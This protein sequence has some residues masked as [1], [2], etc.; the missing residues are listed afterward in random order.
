MAVWALA[1]LH[2]SFGVPNKEMDVFGEVWVNHPKKIEA[3][4][5]AVVGDDDLVLIAGDISW[6]KHL[7][8]S[9]PDLEWIDSLPGT[10]VMIRGNHDYWWSA[11]S[12][13][14]RILPPSI[15]VIQNDSFS[16]HE[17]VTVGGARLWDNYEFNFDGVVKEID[18]DCIKPLTETDLDPKRAEKI[19]NRELQRL[20]KSLRSLNPRAKNRIVMTHYPPV[21]P[22]LEDTRVS[23][24]LE[25][26]RVDICV[27]G[28]VHSLRHGVGPLFGEKN[29]VRYHM[30]AGDYLDFHPLKLID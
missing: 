5:R 25:H 12:K 4:W 29:G 18:V 2:L 15:H 23:K 11:I 27:F 10:K 13:V 17:E 7:E 26:Y 3:N 8:E 14:R 1:D 28:H 20:E 9:F 6:A 19:F 22:Q 24:M 30:T 21:G 16:W